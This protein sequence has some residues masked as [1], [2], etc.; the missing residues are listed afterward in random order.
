MKKIYVLTVGIIFSL[1]LSGC[2][3]YA[4]KYLERHEEIVNNA[5]QQSKQQILF[6]E[7][8]KDE[9]DLFT[10]I[11]EEGRDNISNVTD[12]INQVLAVISDSKKL[13]DKEKSNVALVDN[14]LK[15]TEKML[16]K[17]KDNEQN[18]K[19]KNLH[20][21]FMDRQAIYVKTL[22]KY[23][24]LLDL[25]KELYSSLMKGSELKVVSNNID[26]INEVGKEVTNLVKEFN[27]M[28]NQYNKINI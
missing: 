26:V 1:L 2:S 5:L 4:E 11:M 13:I 3:N 9:E 14:Q 15:D 7:L 8:N 21:T 6:K 16:N 12:K 24:Y 27:E 28:T 20:K 19:I 18:N 23:D 25:E 10:I 17:L 22:D